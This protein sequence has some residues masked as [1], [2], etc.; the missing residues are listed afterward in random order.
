MERKAII[1][2]MDGTIINTEQTWR[3]ATHEVIKKR[4]IPITEKL[5]KELELI[6]AGVGL[7]RGCKILK[8]LLELEEEI[9]EIAREKNSL[10]LQLLAQEIEF[11]EGFIEFHA[12]AKELNLKT[13]LATNADD[14]ALKIANDTLKLE[15]FFG[16]HIYN[17]SHVGAYKPNPA[18]YLY[19]AKQLG[20]TPN[21]CIAIEDSAHGV[22]AAVDAGLYCI[23]FNPSKNR[24]LVCQA[25]HVVHRYDEIDLKNFLKSVCS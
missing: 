4:G 6:M 2:D 3:K 9:E 13:A 15:R 1:F 21:E 23:G 17:V 25:H 11:I 19:A 20:H 18:M 8:E 16:D 12:Q 14:D 24:D 7:M 22:K 10:A 5:H